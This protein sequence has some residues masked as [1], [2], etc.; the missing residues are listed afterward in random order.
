MSKRVSKQA[1]KKALE[2]KKKRQRLMW[3]IGM[4]G[5]LLI[6]IAA[7]VSLS[8]VPSSVA[9]YEID[10]SDT[11]SVALGQQVYATNCAS[12]HGENLEGEENWRES[13]PNGLIKAPPHDETG[14]TWHH[15]NEYLIEAT[16]KGGARLAGA[17]VGISPMPA[18]ED[19]LSSEEVAAVLAYIQSSWPEDI[20]VA[21]ASR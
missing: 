1:R 10:P 16:N 6:L 13:D 21:Q 18:Y 8:S 7:V 3:G 17:N 4:L 20:R 11:A 5:V 9:S 15:S 14:H 12:C 19:I 2:N